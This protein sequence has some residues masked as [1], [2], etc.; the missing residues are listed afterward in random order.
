MDDAF[1]L[2]KKKYFIEYFLKKEYLLKKYCTLEE[3]TW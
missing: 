3:C 2:V 1:T